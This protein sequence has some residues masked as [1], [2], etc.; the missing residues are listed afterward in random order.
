[1]LQRRAER[2]WHLAHSIQL[3]Q[4]EGQGTWAGQLPFLAGFLEVPVARDP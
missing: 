3:G 4:R 2:G 1:M